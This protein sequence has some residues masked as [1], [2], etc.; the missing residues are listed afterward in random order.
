[1]VDIYTPFGDAL[2]HGVYVSEVED[3][4][5]ACYAQYCRDHGR[6]DLIDIP[7]GAS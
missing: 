5:K 2:T 6:A 1:M 7:V 4:V 3:E